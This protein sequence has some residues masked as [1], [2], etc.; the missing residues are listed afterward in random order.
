MQ[1]TLNCALTLTQFLRACK[2]K[3][4][5]SRLDARNFVSFVKSQNSEHF[6]RYKIVNKVRRICA[7]AIF[8]TVLAIPAFAGIMD[9]PGVVGTIDSPG[10]P[11]AA[12]TPSLTSSTS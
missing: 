6:W 8:T 7:V 4:H 9:A 10:A 11:A 5:R 1:A 12:P 2:K 3:V